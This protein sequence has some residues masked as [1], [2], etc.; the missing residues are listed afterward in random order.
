MHN[1][2]GFVDM[3]RDPAV[4]RGRRDELSR[5][6]VWE[7]GGRI[8]KDVIENRNRVAKICVVDIA[9]GVAASSRGGGTGRAVEAVALEGSGPDIDQIE[10]LANLLARD[11]WLTVRDELDEMSREAG[12]DPDRV[13]MDLANHGWCDLI[14][15]IVRVTEVA[16]GVLGRVENGARSAIVYLMMR[17]S[18]QSGRQQAVERVIEFLVDKVWS[19]FIEVLRQAAP[20]LNVLT[21]EDLL[22][23]LRIFAVFVCPAPA[24]HVEVREHALEPLGEDARGYLTEQTREYLGQVFLQVP[25]KA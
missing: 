20:P 7:S 4:R 10:M 15:G 5:K 1:V 13:R 8:L 17:S 6:L 23:A 11:V 19:T 2:R 14:V 16:A 24:R 18:M 25:R 3:S 9:E 12:L 21:N 22:R